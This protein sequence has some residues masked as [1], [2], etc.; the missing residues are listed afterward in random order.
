L[1]RVYGVR[2]WEMDE[3]T[4]GEIAR[5]ADDIKQMKRQESS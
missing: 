2:P 3:F 1:A 4:A 5:I